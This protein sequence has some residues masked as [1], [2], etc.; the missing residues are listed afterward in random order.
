[1]SF[2]NN[3]FAYRSLEQALNTLTRGYAQFYCDQW[4]KLTFP[5]D[6]KHHKDII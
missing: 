5:F 6:T 2:T 3:T 1:M 4:G